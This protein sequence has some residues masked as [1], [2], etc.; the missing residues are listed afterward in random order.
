MTAAKVLKRKHT[1]QKQK[2]R[3]KAEQN[4]QQEKKS[5]KHQQKSQNLCPAGECEWTPEM[6]SIRSDSSSTSAPPLRWEWAYHAHWGNKQQDIDTFS[7]NLLNKQHNNKQSSDQHLA[8]SLPGLFNNMKPHFHSPS[9]KTRMRKK[10]V[11]MIDD[12]PPQ[13]F[14]FFLLHSSSQG[15]MIKA[16]FI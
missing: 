2:T 10:F 15:R 9:R 4:K 7:I 1:L 5:L 3:I 6:F 11:E 13:M 12:K 14:Y 16:L 8:H